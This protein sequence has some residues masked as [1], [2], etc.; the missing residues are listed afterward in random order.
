MEGLGSQFS[1]QGCFPTWATP[2][3][4]PEMNSW[5]L[6]RVCTDPQEYGAPEWGADLVVSYL[7]GSEGLLAEE[8]VA[9][10]LLSV[11]KEE[12]IKVVSTC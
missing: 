6:M 10:V 7:D 1:L 8:V 3:E 4:L 2:S 9:N 11:F 12:N 5:M